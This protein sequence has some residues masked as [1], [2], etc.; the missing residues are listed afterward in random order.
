MAK[1][2]M[3]ANKIHSCYHCHKTFESV[4]YDAQFCSSRCRVA[5]KRYLDHVAEIEKEI[6][7][8]LLELEGYKSGD[9]IIR[10]Q[11]AAARVYQLARNT[12]LALDD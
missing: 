6:G 1:H 9:G 7:A 10:A 12:L 4:R 3:W 2:Q 8:L 5:H 11:T